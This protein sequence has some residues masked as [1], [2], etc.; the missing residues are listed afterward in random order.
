MKDV[1]KDCVM[2]NQKNRVAMN[3]DVKKKS[4]CKKL[5]LGEGPRQQQSSGQ[6]RISVRYP[7]EEAEDRMI[8]MSGMQGESEM[9]IYF[10]KS[11]AGRL[12]FNHKSG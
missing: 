5:I 9:E 10:K 4:D 1:F 2:S 12:Y 7:S 11:S 8:C 3:R 6:L